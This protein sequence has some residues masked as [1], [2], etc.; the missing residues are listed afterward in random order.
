MGKY[1]FFTVL[2]A[3]LILA[4]CTSRA[5]IPEP[6]PTP[7]ISMAPAPGPTP[8]PTPTPSPSP[9]PEPTPEP[10]PEPGPEEF[11]ISFVGDCTLASS[12]HHKGGSRAFEKIVGDDYAFPFAETAQYFENDYLSIANMEGTFTTSQRSNGATFTFKSD[13][14]Y[15]KIFAEGG[16]ELVTLGNNHS[17]DYGEQGSQ[18]TKDA[19]EAAGVNYAA[20]DG[21][22]IY[23]R[24]DGLSVGVY[25][26]LYPTVQDV[27]RGVGALRD[28]GAELII[29]AVHWG[30]EGSYRVTADQQAVGHAAI[31]AGA[32]IVYGSHPHVLQ[33]IEE[34]GDG[35]IL[36]S[37]GNWSFG[38][39]TAPRDRDTAIIRIT[40]VREA[41]GS[42]SLGGTELIACELSSE[43]SQNNYQPHPYDPDSKEYARAMS[44]LD[45]SFKGPD[46][47]VDY[48][49]FNQG[50]GAEENSESAGGGDE[51]QG[52]GEIQD[53]GGEL[54]QEDGT[55]EEVPAA[56]PETVP[57]MPGTMP[58]MPESVPELPGA[59]PQPP[60]E[61]ESGG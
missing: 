28:A 10:A 4:G 2:A 26:K 34:Y 48:S 13:P 38:G 45:G 43:P 18:D 8:E 21:V 17:M 61:P 24:D 47:V 49:A 7:E 37:L 54:R 51:A 59:V 33:K 16:I 15:A 42:V 50:G 20:E 60:A 32:D 12:Q 29:A 53:G 22:F 55:G 41:D 6:G 56:P 40:A 44:K 39:N 52:E 30:V 23:Q 3:A 31:D 57:E 9:T 19:L 36:Y 1:V 46:L 27:K 58:E 5:A 11:V 35:I 14:D 25:S